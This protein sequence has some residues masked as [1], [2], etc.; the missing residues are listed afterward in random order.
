MNESE[1][2]SEHIFL[3]LEKFAY[4]FYQAE[5]KR[6]RVAISLVIRELIYA[7]LEKR[8]VKNGEL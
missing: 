7:D 3:R 1:K 2:K 6:R 4:D 8:G 5:A